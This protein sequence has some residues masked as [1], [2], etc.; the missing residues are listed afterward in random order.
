MTGLTELSA[1]ISAEASTYV[2]TVLSSP[3]KMVAAL[4]VAIGIGLVIAGSFMRTMLPLRWLAAGSDLSMLIFGALAPSISTLLIAGALLPINIFRA[5]EV[6]R[7]TRRV[8]RAQANAGFSGL[9]LRP[10]MTSRRLEAGS[11]LFRKGDDAHHLYL[12]VSGELELSDIGK[13]LETGR[14][15][16]EI[17]LFSP[18]H[19]RTHT[20]ACISA[21]HVLEIHE[22]TVKQ[23]Y[24][25][26]PTFGFHLMELLVGRLSADI[27]RNGTK[28][29]PPSRQ[30]ED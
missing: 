2:A 18:S 26:N 8:T 24:F 16:G 29:A 25:Q 1:W 30:A 5:L 21:C 9:W 3:S 11:V 28:G 20:A 6:T 27:E 23:L 19:R 4:A 13:R 12:L 14:I 22:R 17:A 7:L 15:F 10:Y